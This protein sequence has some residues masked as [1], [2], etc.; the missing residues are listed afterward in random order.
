MLLFFC[1]SSI[2]DREL[3]FCITFPLEVDAL[4]CLSVR[5]VSQQNWTSDVPWRAQSP[6]PP[7]GSAFHG[8]HRR[9]CCH[10]MVC[11]SPLHFVFLISCG[12]SQAKMFAK[13]ENEA[14]RKQQNKIDIFTTI[15][16]GDSTGWCVITLIEES[17][18]VWIAVQLIS[19]FNQFSYVVIVL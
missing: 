11:R 10:E 1:L 6:S 17:W 5:G 18:C 16:S 4:N 14:T 2:L 13:S 7:L 19:L 8:R 3:P 9:I 12:K 15:S